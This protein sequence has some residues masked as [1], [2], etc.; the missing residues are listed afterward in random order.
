[1]NKIRIAGAAAG[2]VLVSGVVMQVSSAAFTDTTDNTNNSWA[3]GTVALTDDDAGSALYATQ[4]DIIPG[5][6]EVR[7]IEVSYSG[8]VTPSAAIKLYALVT[9]TGAPTTDNGLSDD[10]DVQ[11]EIGPADSACN[12]T[13]TGFVDA[14]TRLLTRT[15]TNIFTGTLAV[16]ND[17]NSPK[18]TAWTPD[19][20]NGAD[21]MRPFLFTVN[22]PDAS[23]P[24]DAQGDSAT[25]AFTWSATS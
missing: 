22:M 20:A 11:V 25:A 13:D 9:S 12:N 7:C 10:L 2:V 1:M 19:S 15:G 18:S 8:S 4:A 24:N 3:A 14:A 6:S 16:F 23:T 17:V 5:Y 21:L